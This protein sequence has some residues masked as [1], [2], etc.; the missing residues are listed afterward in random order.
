MVEK[1]SAQFVDHEVRLDDLQDE[2]EPPLR[3][4]SVCAESN[5][6]MSDDGIETRDRPVCVE[7]ALLPAAG[8]SGL[9]VE[10][11]QLHTQL[12]SS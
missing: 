7:V 2:D 9:T 6:G 11:V 5:D 8:G 10:R 3:S 1:Y 4:G 12:S